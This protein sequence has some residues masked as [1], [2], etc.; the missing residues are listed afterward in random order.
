VPPLLTMMMTPSLTLGLVGD[1][2][3]QAAQGGGHH[4]R[5]PSAPHRAGNRRDL[6]VQF[7]QGTVHGSQGQD[8]TGS[9]RQMGILYLTCGYW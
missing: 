6:R 3:E 4:V 7:P 8:L 5:H 2:D 9:G 1:S